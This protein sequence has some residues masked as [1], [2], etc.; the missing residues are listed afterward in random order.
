LAR[1]L[2]PLQTL[3]AALYSSAVSYV[4]LGALSP[5]NPDDAPSVGAAATRQI[6]LFFSLAALA[7]VLFPKLRIRLI[8]TALVVM[9]GA[10]EILQLAFFSGHVADILDVVSAVAGVGIALAPAVI[11]REF[12]LQPRGAS[13]NSLG[14]LP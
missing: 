13:P 9:A 7:V 8:G 10:I 1:P 12:P 14:F 3:K 5:F 11:G 2:T 4:L 6:L